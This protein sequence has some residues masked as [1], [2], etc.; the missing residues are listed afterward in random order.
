MGNSIS[1]SRLHPRPDNWSELRFQ[2]YWIGENAK[3]KSADFDS[4]EQTHAFSPLFSGAV[5][6]R[7]GDNIEASLVFPSP[8][9]Q[10]FL[11]QAVRERWTAVVSCHGKS[12]TLKRQRFPTQLYRYTGIVAGG[13]WRTNV[14]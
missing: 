5:L 10:N 8:T 12:R 2:N 13:G 1:A 6:S 11:D 9:S 4:P 3:W 7:Q 14:S